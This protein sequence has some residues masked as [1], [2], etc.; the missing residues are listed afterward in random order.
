MRKLVIVGAGSWAQSIVPLFDLE[1]RLLQFWDVPRKEGETIFEKP[2]IDEFSKDY[3]NLDFIAIAGEPRNKRNLVRS[4]VYSVNFQGRGRFVNLIWEGTLIVKTAQIGEGILIQPDSKIYHKARIGD[5]V[6]IAGNV[7]ISH[8]AQ[9][10]EFCTLSPYSIVCG[11]AQLRDGV[12]LGAGAT[13]LPK[14]KV[15][16]GAVIGAGAVVTKEVPQDHVI[17]GNPAR[18]IKSVASWWFG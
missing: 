15:G 9:I 17:V 8:D 5:H 2:V 4:L 6:S 3:S 14:V 10:G 11:G 18:D 13:I 12:F 7:T 16:G 1:E